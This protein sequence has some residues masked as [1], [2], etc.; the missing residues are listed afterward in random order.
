L[1]DLSTFDR[2]LNRCLRDVLN[3][4]FW[5]ENVSTLA[6][7]FVLWW[8]L[9]FDCNLTVP[10]THHFTETAGFVIPLNF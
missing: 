7:N 9:N 4:E 3:I 1:D 6:L 8:Y 2:T 5:N 10:Q